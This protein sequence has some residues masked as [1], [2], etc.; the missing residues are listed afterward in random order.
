MD[1]KELLRS[2]KK[3]KFPQDIIDAFD[4]VNREDFIPQ[5]SRDMA[6]KDTALPIGKGQTISQPYIIAFM[7]SLLKLESEKKQKILEI[8][9]GSGYVLALLN[10]ITGKDSEIYGIERI[11]ELA[12]RS[13]EILKNKNVKVIHGDG[14]KGLP[15][16]KPF[17]R[18]IVSAAADEIPSKLVR[19]LKVG[20]ILVVP[21]KNS[22]YQIQRFTN[23]NK[24]QE[25]PGF[26]F[27]P[28]IEEE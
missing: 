6:Y 7:L 18:I 26:R 22:I 5:S 25:F 16:Q 19:Q 9:S 24:I 23:D 20:G 11:K 2:L 27:V 21:V 13:Q 3:Q 10:E 17:D 12:E 28:L 15:K 4:K 8:G 1:K 14:S